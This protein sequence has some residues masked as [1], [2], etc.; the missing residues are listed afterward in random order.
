MAAPCPED[1]PND[2]TKQAHTSG[3]GLK[4][5]LRVGHGL[6]GSDRFKV[7]N[8]AANPTGEIHFTWS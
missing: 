6:P 1:T 4:I 5:K 8:Q 3:D 2:L 7:S